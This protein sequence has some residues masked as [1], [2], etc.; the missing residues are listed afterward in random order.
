[1]EAKI[2]RVFN[3]YIAIRPALPVMSIVETH[4]G[5]KYLVITSESSF[6]RE[7]A[8]SIEALDEE[9]LKNI[10]LHADSES[11][12]IAVGGIRRIPKA[13]EKVRLVGNFF[14]LT[15]DEP[16]VTPLGPFD[17]WPRGMGHVAIHGKTGSGKSVAATHL[18]LRARE[19][20]YKV[21][22]LDF[23]GEYREMYEDLSRMGIRAIYYDVP[24]VNVCKAPPEALAAIF[25]IIQVLDRAPKMMHY[26]LRVAELAC[27][28]PR[29]IREL[30]ED[31]V[32]LLRALIEAIALLPTLEDG[33]KN[34]RFGEETPRLCKIYNYIRRKY[35]GFE[36]RLLRDLV[37]KRDKDSIES[38]HRYSKAAEAFRGIVT[39]DEDIELEGYD[40]VYINL[41]IGLS[42]ISYAVPVAIY[43]IHRVMQSQERI[44]LFIEE[45]PALMQDE[46]IRRAIENIV[47]Q[48]RKFGKFVVLIT[49]VP[50][51]IMAQ[52]NLLVGNIA[53][54]RYIKEVLVR[55]PHMSDA[56][57]YILP[58][59]PPWHFIYISST[60]EILPV[61][62]LRKVVRHSA[63]E[64]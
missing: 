4:D 3:Q 29:E 40:F 35:E 25:G 46:Y 10:V 5:N 8:R 56:L 28:A 14:E 20:G 51:E 1:M 6:D 59:L 22:V 39:I 55:T 12:A 19:K 54:V 45:A 63:S 62:I 31:P 32:D 15:S 47:R 34:A 7:V 17:P 9:D 43:V 60:G 30:F 18:M 52:M 41:S 61:K 11:K 44:V 27:D 42:H 50:L 33:C 49:Q 23:H 37:D 2:V 21:V 53:N 48:G 57:R 58:L 38:L 26:M 64:I 36:Y 13:G 24:R 16:V